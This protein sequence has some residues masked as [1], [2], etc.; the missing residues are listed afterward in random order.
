[1]A[2]NIEGQKCFLA[3]GKMYVAKR[4]DCFP[5]FKRE[6]L[7]FVG[8]VL[9]VAVNQDIEKQSQ[10]DYTTP[11]G[12]NACVSYEVNEATLA[13]TFGSS[14]AKVFEIV[15]GGEVQT[16]DAAAAITDEV[17]SIKP[18]ADR[19]LLSLMPDTSVPFVVTSEDGLTTYDL[20]DDYLV[21]D[22]GLEV[23]EGGDLDLAV[24]GAVDEEL[25]ILVSYTHTTQRVVKGLTTTGE[26]YYVVIEG[27][28]KISGRA[29]RFIFPKIRFSPSASIAVLTEDIATFEAEGELFEA[30][31][32]ARY[33]IIEVQGV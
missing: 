4:K 15:T 24:Q 9:D 29:L 3:R 13:L 30:D 23:V 6:A 16:L 14:N 28:N 8:N 33:E 7:Q 5:E 11:A 21:T 31:G 25:S 18:G 20:T 22:Y 10:K 2:C 19:V 1:M 26:D 17:H 32:K 12:G 27:V